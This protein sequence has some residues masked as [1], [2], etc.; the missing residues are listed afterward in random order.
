MNMPV[1]KSLQINESFLNFV[2]QELLPESTLDANSFWEQ[3]ESLVNKFM[4]KNQALLTKR[5]ELQQ[6]LDGFYREFRAGS[7]RLHHY[8]QPC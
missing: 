8:H 2:N 6:Q 5:E 1:S 4:P 7:C 3:F